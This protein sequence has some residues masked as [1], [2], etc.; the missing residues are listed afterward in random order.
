MRPFLAKADPL[1]GME[2]ELRYTTHE[3]FGPDQAGASSI[4][5]GVGH[6]KQID[7]YPYRTVP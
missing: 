4:G 2:R 6:A 5:K 7:H 1:I 3:V